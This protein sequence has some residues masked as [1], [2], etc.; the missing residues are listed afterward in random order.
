MRRMRGA[1]RV[2]LFSLFPGFSA[3]AHSVND[4]IP[5]SLLVVFHK[6]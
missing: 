2:R 5:L 6:R 1:A 3:C 4:I